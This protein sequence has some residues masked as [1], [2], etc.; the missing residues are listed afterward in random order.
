M[1][2]GR[3]LAVL[4]AAVAVVPGGLPAPGTSAS[5]SDHGSAPTAAHRRTTWSAQFD[6][7]AGKQPGRRTWNYQ[8]GNAAYDG[9]GN[10]ELEYYTSRRKNVAMDGRGHL[11]ITARRSSPDAD[12]PCW[13]GQPCPYTSARLT[14]QGKRTFD[15]GRIAIRM[16]LPPG[17]GLW[18]AFWMMGESS[19][20]WPQNG[21]IDVMEVVGDRPHTVFGTAH[22][23]GYSG[24][25]GIGGHLTLDRPLTRGFH[26]YALAKHHRSLNWFVDGQR[27][28]RLERAD[29]PEGKRWVFN[30]PFHLLLNLAVG[31]SWPGTPPPDTHF[32]A[33]LRVGWIKMSEH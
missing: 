20:P 7:H 3:R 29:L 32:P 30:Q 11:V 5:E 2:A 10:E 28:F 22:G 9:W 25:D 24:A 33:Q 12:R 15:T 23:P 16:D 21:E 19:L 4:V 18:P 8:H 31:G 27:Y 26:R 1:R 6:G 17:R 13:D 14:T